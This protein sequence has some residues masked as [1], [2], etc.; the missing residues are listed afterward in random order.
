MQVETNIFT[1][2]AKKLIIKPQ[3]KLPLKPIEYPQ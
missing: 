2:F 3:K 1:Q